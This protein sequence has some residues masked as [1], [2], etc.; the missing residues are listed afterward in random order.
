MRKCP[1]SPRSPLQLKC[2]YFAIASICKAYLTIGIMSPSWECTC[3]LW[4]DYYVMYI[5]PQNAVQFSNHRILC[6]LSKDGVGWWRWSCTRGAHMGAY[7]MQAIAT[8]MPSL[9]LL[10]DI[11]APNILH[12]CTNLHVGL[13]VHVC[14]I[15]CVLGTNMY[16]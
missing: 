13:H 7:S 11:S 15:Y 3:M 16:M 6:K 5:A 2:V 8:E 12:L 1:I 10:Y 9:H 14:V 4:K